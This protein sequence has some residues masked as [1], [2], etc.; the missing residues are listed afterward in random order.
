MHAARPAGGE[1]A[2]PAEKKPLSSGRK[3]PPPAGRL[4]AYFSMEIGL[5]ADIPTYAGGLG[6]LAG[7]T[8]RA[9]ADLEVPM[10]AVTLLHRKGYFHQSLGSEGEQKESPV[11]WSPDDFL[12]HTGA[13][14]SVQISGRSVALTAWRLDVTGVTGYTVPVY[15]IDADLPANAQEDRD[16]TQ[17]L[18]GGDSGYRLR[19]EVLLGIGGVRLLRSLGHA[20][21][22]RYH[23]NEGHSS[24]LTAELYREERERGA[25]DPEALESMRERC[26][27]TTHTPVPAGHD[28]FPM[29]LASGVLGD[30]LTP[31][32]QELG[33]RKGKLNLTWLALNSSRYVNG[34]ARRHGE[35]SREMFAP[36]PVDFITNGVH[37][38]TWAAPPLAELFDRRVPTWRAGSADLR[39]ALGIPRAEIIDAHREAKKLLLHRANRRTNTGLDLDVFTLG[40]ARRMT[41]YKQPDLVFS[42][43]GRLKALAAAAGPIQMVFAGKAHPRDDGGRELIKFIFKCREAL[44][45]DV[46]IAYMPNYDM[47]IGRLIT[48]GVD[49]WL[50]T[51]TPPMEASGTSGMKA[52]LNGVP[53]LSILDGWWIE[54]CVEGVTGWAIAPPVGAEAVTK[55][56]YAAELYGKLERAVLPMYYGDRSAWA[57]VMLHAI[58]LNGSWFNTQRMVR[59][60]V[61][62]AYL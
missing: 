44:G 51:P 49:L 52:A 35:V 26:I 45:S 33:L 31:A 46:R 14:A 17:W 37:A 7:D 34:V 48:S 13:K 6:I 60:Y 38:A 39:G 3:I 56:R 16:L 22:R 21:I 50:N 61:V 9:A 11:V 10:V 43:I 53:S 24:L 15:F 18:Y 55:E 47:E 27:F 54:G 40:F 59:E 30:L 41:P 5:D 36:H 42:D 8:I 2:T 20:G 1:D 57:N 12:R 29:D 23:M 32:I 62:K 58:A 25:G 19:Q 4:V 28:R